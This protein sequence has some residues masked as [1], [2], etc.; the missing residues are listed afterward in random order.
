VAQRR[1]TPATRLAGWIEGYRSGLKV[2]LGSVAATF[3]LL[4][5]LLF[6]PA[7]SL[8]QT[9]IT[10]FQPKQI[11]PVYVTSADLQSLPALQKYGTVHAPSSVQPRSVADAAAA[12]RATGMT[13]LTPSSLPSGVPASVAYRVVDSATGTFTFNAAKA[14]H[15]AHALGKHLRAMPAGVNGSTLKVTTGAAVVATYGAQGKG[16]I[17]TLV[18]GQMVAPQVSSTGV[19]VKEL[20]NYIFSLPGVSPQLASA[21]RSINDPTSTLPIPI[22]MDKAHADRITIDG[23]SGLT[24]GDATGLGSAVIWE[25]DGIIYGVG[26]PLPQSQVI[27]IARS[28]H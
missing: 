27:D 3:A 22:P 9:F 21:L 18:I 15:A 2:G 10:I 28:L 23:V 5:A 17:P 8:A 16:A 1:N 4:G 24:I 26:G 11:T 14:R 12:A 19:T 6:T 13:V 7:G 20:E 25:K